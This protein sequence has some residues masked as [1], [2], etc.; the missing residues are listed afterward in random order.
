MH[1]CERISTFHAILMV[2]MRVIEPKELRKRPAKKR[3]KS[4]RGRL[5]VLLATVVIVFGGIYGV[6]AYS[7]PLPSTSAQVVNTVAA[8]QNV[9]LP[10]PSYG[11]A[12]I[13]AQ[14]YGVLASSHDGLAVPIASIAKVMVA[15]AVLRQNPLSPGQQG[16]MITIS[17]ADVAL[18]QQA[19]AQGGSVVEVSEGEQISEYQAL[20]A[21]LL[22]SANNIADSLANWA[23][24]SA[25]AYMSYANNMAKGIG[26]AQTHI[27]DASGFSP[28]SVSTASDLVKLGIAAMRSPVLAEIVA[29]QQADIPVAGTVYNVNYLLGE[30][31]IVGIKTGNTASAGGCYLFAAIRVAASGQSITVVGAILGAPSLSTAIRDAQ[32]LLGAAYQGFGTIT[33]I[34]AGQTVANYSL[35]WGSYVSAVAQKNLTIFGWRG[36]AY[37]PSI[38]LL[39]LQSPHPAGFRVGTIGVDSNSGRLSVPIVLSKSISAPTGRWRILH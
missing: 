30:D 13:G 21:M 24:G 36:L 27:A 14:D 4:H 28:G 22:P 15:L 29:Q 11:Q 39:A 7:R 6:L 8:A 2:I 35:P 31:G 38:G 1:R 18:Y 20:Q 25:D 9:N 5:F 33:V 19:A 17:A 10:W 3:R 34:R 37:K 26:M 12:A 32:P 23:F 16:P